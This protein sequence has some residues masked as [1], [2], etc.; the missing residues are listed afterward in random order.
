MEQLPYWCTEDELTSPRAFVLGTGAV[1][2]PSDGGEVADS[3]N[4]SQPI[5]CEMVLA[6]HAQAAPR[7]S[8]SAPV[9]RLRVDSGGFPAPGHPHCSSQTHGSGLHLNPVHS[10]QGHSFHFVSGSENRLLLSYRLNVS[11]QNSY[12]EV[13]VPQHVT[14]FEQCRCR[15]NLLR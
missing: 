9:W 11:S 12:V 4:G 5:L 7:A 10:A 2:A 1:A 8:A 13:S 15:Y 6:L 14:L 3:R